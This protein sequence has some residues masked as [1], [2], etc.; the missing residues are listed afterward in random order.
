MK[1]MIILLALACAGCHEQPRS[2]DGDAS[3]APVLYR[4]PVTKCEYL[5]RGN[6]G[7]LTPRMRADGQQICGG[8]Q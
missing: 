2:G 1:T 8:Q 7:G 5:S 3:Y 6:L 4:D